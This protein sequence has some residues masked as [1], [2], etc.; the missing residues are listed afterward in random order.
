[1]EEP[2]HGDREAD[3]RAHWHA[4]RKGRGDR[5]GRIR[6]EVRRLRAIAGAREEDGSEDSLG[7][8]LALAYPDRIGKR[9][10]DG[11]Y[12]LSGGTGAVLPAGSLL[13]RHEFL[14]VA[15]LDASGADAM[16]RLAA[17]VSRETL[18]K[19][20]GP[21]LNDQE[22]I[23]WDGQAVTGRRLRLLGKIALEER[24][25]EVDPETALTAL[26][27][28]VRAMGLACL[29]WSA[30]CRSLRTR[31]EWLRRSGFAPGVWPDLTDDGLLADL[32]EWL[33]PHLHGVTRRSQLEKLDTCGMLRAYLGHRRMADLERMAPEFLA[34]P[35]GSRIRLDYE[36]GPV[37]AVKLQEMFGQVNTPTVA[38]G[39]A[40]VL[41]HLLSPAGRPLA[42]TQDL[43]NFWQ[44][45][46]PE[47]RK[48]MRGRY[49]K[50][51]WPE[52]PLSAIPTRRTK[53]RA[54]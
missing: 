2:G 22:E 26:L 49:P 45:V 20:F 25:L 50:H 41:I 36:S 52:D 9:R 30:G 8:L 44:K 18:L 12:L 29:S 48:E 51:P 47:V 10:P 24:P 3:F 7:I 15:H 28:G 43:P 33:G 35:T 40:A 34:V 39:K 19:V 53:K 23:K 16:V 1:L 27:E 4:V 5:E 42:I 17:P 54:K 32:P 6:R 46:Y 21:V 37:L 11:R 38:G 13:A 31:S 14:A